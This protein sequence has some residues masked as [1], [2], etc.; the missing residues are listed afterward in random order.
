VPA[1][2]LTAPDGTAVRADVKD[3]GYEFL[4]PNQRSYEE[5][6]VVWTGG[7]GTPHVQPTVTFAAVR[8]SACKSSAKLTQSVARVSPD[9]AF[10]CTA[11]PMADKFPVPVPRGAPRALRLRRQVAAMVY[12]T[13]CTAS[14]PSDRAWWSPAARAPCRRSPSCPLAR[15]RRRRRLGPSRR[16][17]RPRPRHPASAADRPRAPSSL[18]EMAAPRPL[19]ILTLLAVFVASVSV[20]ILAWIAI[21]TAHHAQDVV[22]KADRLTTDAATSIR[23]LDRTTRDLDPAV[24][25]LRRASDALN[26]AARA[27]P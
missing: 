2:F 5:R 19:V 26:N 20:T 8:A 6:Y 24:R 1:V 10:P 13:R 11:G 9:G 12:V 7:D 17:R 4:L 23:R 16:P 18:D 14:F 25:S 21:A 22:D 15:R 27:T 3:N